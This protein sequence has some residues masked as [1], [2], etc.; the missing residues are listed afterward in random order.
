MPAVVDFYCCAGGAAT[1]LAKAGFTRIVGVDHR[2]MPHYPYEFVQGDALEL[3]ADPAFMAQFDAGWGSPPCQDHSETKVLRRAAH[4]TGHL[5]AA[6]RAGFVA[7]GKSWAL[8]N[9]QGAGLPQQGTLDGDHGLVLCGCMFDD[10]RGLVYEDRVFEASFP[11]PQPLHTYHRWRQ[12]KMGRPPVDGECMQITGHFAG[13][14][15]AQRRTGLTWMTQ[16]ELAQAIPWQ[17]AEYVGQY[18]LAEVARAVAA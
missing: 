11:L 9:V 18:M 16:D 5:L 10:L 7:W 14:A 4:G 3:L 17:Y 8:E 6:T 15:E 13:V 1:G 12:T 2:P